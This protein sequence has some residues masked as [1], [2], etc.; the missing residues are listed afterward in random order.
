MK[1]NLLIIG[2]GG[3]GRVVADVAGRTGNYRSIAF[4]DDAPACE[5]LP[6]PCLGGC[7]DAERFLNDHDV[8]VAIGNGAVRKRIMEKLE[9]KGAGFATVIAPEAVIGSNVRI[10]QGSVIMPGVI[11]NTGTSIGRGVILNTA[12]SVDHDCVVGDYCHVAVGAHLCGT[13][14]VEPL[15]WIG[16]GAVVINNVRICAE[17]TLGAGAVVV[18][19][20]LEPCTVVGCPARPL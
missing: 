15:S 8:C 19:D 18:K 17:C 7:G 20:I 14:Q 1:E 4:L 3:H 9:E 16:A 10:G 13:V 2:A 11:V 12:C 5:G 6:Y